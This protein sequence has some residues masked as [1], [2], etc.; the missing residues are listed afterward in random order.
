MSSFQG[1]THGCV[2]CGLKWEMYVSPQHATLCLVR[3]SALSV[4]RLLISIDYKMA[5]L[6]DLGFPDFAFWPYKTAS[7]CMHRRLKYQWSTVVYH[8][9]L[10]IYL[11]GCPLTSSPSICLERPALY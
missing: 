2:L 1:F 9:L 10:C 3:E 7:Q 8:Y 4:S 5:L 11:T 6:L